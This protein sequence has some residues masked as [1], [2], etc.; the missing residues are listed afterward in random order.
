MSKSK[1]EPSRHPVRRVRRPT[2]LTRV[3]A[4]VAK[5]PETSEKLAWGA[6]TF[7][8]GGTKMFAMFLDD[9]HGDGRTALWL[10]AAV[11]VQEALVEADP[12]RFFRP[13]YVGVKG[14][15]GLSLDGGVDWSEVAHFL[16]EAYRLAAPARL[17]KK[18]DVPAAV[19]PAGRVT[20][21]RRPA[22]RA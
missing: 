19:A 5:L 10:P 21:A 16:T 9:H 4:M 20:R 22:R 14:W 7:R 2:V 3:R 13:P 11:G 1:A 12:E 6:P 17:V 15:I 18:L 8:A